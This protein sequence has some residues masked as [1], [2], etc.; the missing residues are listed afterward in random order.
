MEWTNDKVQ[1]SIPELEEQSCQA[2]IFLFFIFVCV[3]LLLPSS[4]KSP[5]KSLH[6]EAS[7]SV[8]LRDFN[9]GQEKVIQASFSQTWAQSRPPLAAAY[10]GALETYPMTNYKVN[11]D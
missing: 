6:Q 7:V 9:G 8:G 5:E 11:K 10:G 1:L 2:P 3:I 4:L